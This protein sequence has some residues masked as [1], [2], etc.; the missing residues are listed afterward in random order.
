MVVDREEVDERLMLQE[1][2]FARFHERL[3]KELVFMRE[4]LLAT[5]QRSPEVDGVCVIAVTTRK[6][7][8]QRLQIQMS[9]SN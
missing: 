9:N 3:P 8:R 4:L 6:K 7:R 5:I 1:E 2:L